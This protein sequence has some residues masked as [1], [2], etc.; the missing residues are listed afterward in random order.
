[1]DHITLKLPKHLSYQR[2]Y[3]LVPLGHE[4]G[5]NSLS[6]EQRGWRVGD[7]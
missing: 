6:T 7:G 1:M 5:L 3:W 2:D 4:S